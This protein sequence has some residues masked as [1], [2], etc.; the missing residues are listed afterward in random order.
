MLQSYNPDVA[1]DTGDSPEVTHARYAA[2]VERLDAA[3][4]RKM[5]SD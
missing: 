5:G 4:W 3:Q 1:P 2:A